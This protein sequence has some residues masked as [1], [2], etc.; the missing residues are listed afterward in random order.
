MVEREGGQQPGDWAAFEAAIR[1]HDRELRAFASRLVTASPVAVDDVLQDAYLEA[2][3]RWSTDR[4]GSSGVSRGLLFGLVYWRSLDALRTLRREMSRQSEV[5]NAALT[6]EPASSVAERHET[7]QDVREAL[8]A[9]TLEGRVVILLVD[10]A[11]F[12]YEE[13]ASVAQVSTGTVASR[14]H[15]ARLRFRQEIERR[16]EQSSVRSS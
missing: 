13:A 1:V 8:A 7:R 9:L 2:F 3:R 5:G 14:L 15:H 12:S 11:G 10:G 6:A 4:S 16:K